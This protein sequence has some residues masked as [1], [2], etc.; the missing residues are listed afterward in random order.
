M[1]EAELERFARHLS[2]AEVGIAGQERLGA[3][4]VHVA[5][6]ASWAVTLRRGLERSG[7]AL[8]ADPAALCVRAGAHEH[9]V[10]FAPGSIEVGNLD[11]D[12]VI[13]AWLGA[14]LASELILWQLGHRPTTYLL[15]LRFPEWRLRLDAT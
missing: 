9:R 13:E 1:N 12:A 2:L 11:N 7:V 8:T 15:E 6:E 5:S 3:I 10:R 14:L 4:R